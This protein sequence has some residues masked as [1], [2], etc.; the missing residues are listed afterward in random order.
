[1]R[2]ERP[3]LDSEQLYSI[4]YAAPHHRQLITDVGPPLLRQTAGGT[5]I[6]DEINVRGLGVADIGIQIAG[7]KYVLNGPPGLKPDIAVIPLERVGGE[8]VRELRN[9][10]DAVRG[11]IIRERMMA[12]TGWRPGDPDPAWSLTTTPLAEFLMSLSGVT[13]F[14]LWSTDWRPFGSAG[15]VEGLNEGVGNAVDAL[16]E[17]I[18]ATRSGRMLKLEGRLGERV[19]FAQDELTRVV[20]QINSTGRSTVAFDGARVGSFGCPGQC[21]MSRFIAKQRVTDVRRARSCGE[22]W[23]VLDLEMPVITMAAIPAE[24]LSAVGLTQ[25]RGPRRPIWAELA[26]VPKERTKI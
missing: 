5:V 23:L 17:N 3:P 26:S 6:L 2:L 15:R 1:M 21:E 25:L 14:D 22:N 4:C 16:P 20:M 13:S 12:A 10:L 11:N 19:E 7:G 8:A 24:A 9:F 18:V